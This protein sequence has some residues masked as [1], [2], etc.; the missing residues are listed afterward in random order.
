MKSL[1][2]LILGASLSACSSLPESLTLGGAAGL[3]VGAYTG[4]VADSGPRHEARAKN[5]AIASSVGLGI[6]LLSS[7]L[8]HR[9]VEKRV[10][11]AAAPA[12]V[13]TYFGDLPPNPFKLQNFPKASDK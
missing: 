11:S 5:I 8:V 6:G 2:V 3:S 9:H 7:Y 4:A 10:E 13:E 12:Q 1:H